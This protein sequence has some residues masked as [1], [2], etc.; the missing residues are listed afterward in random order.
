MT[1]PSKRDERQREADE[2]NRITETIRKALVK[3]GQKKK[4]RKQ[5]DAGKN[6]IKKY[7][8]NRKSKEKKPT[9]KGKND[10]EGLEM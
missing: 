4:K 10:V 5:N 3:S 9:M 2:V 6:Y 7:L 1:D 8:R